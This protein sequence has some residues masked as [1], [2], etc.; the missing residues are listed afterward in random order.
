MEGNI[1]VTLTARELNV[2]L[3]G[4]EEILGRPRIHVRVRA[5]ADR[6]WDKLFDARRE[7]EKQEGE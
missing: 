3:V 1:T 5:A 4:L 6:L 7:Q 2:L